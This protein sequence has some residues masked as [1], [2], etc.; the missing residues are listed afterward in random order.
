MYV[1][2]CDVGDGELVVVGESVADG[3][4]HIYAGERW[5]FPRLW[6]CPFWDDVDA[7]MMLLDSEP[8]LLGML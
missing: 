3:N 5:S 1:V 6:L 4:G 8:Y 2:E 7:R